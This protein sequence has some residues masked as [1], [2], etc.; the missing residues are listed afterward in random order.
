[1]TSASEHSAHPTTNEQP[2]ADSS[3]FHRVAYQMHAAGFNPRL[4]EDEQ[5]V[6][7]T[8]KTED[9]VVIICDEQPSSLI[10]M[11]CSW[12]ID[13]DLDSDE[14]TRARA[15][16]KVNEE[17]KLAKVFFSDDALVA[18]VD[19]L[20]EAMSDLPEIIDMGVSAILFAAASWHEAMG[21]TIFDEHT[22]QS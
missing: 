18:C 10:R 22:Q 4:D 6:I 19:H 7:F 8:L 1:M 21:V 13:S 17:C 14:L 20:V 12:S 15:A 9:D 5:L 16:L 11:F 2:G 3:L